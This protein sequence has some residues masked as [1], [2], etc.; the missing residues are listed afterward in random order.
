MVFRLGIV[1]DESQ[2]LAAIHSR[3]IQIQQGKIG[4]R[5]I[6]KNSL[7][8]EK[9]HGLDAVGGHIQMDGNIGRVK[10][11][12]GQPYISGAVFDQEDF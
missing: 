12:L 1:L 10:G 3:H 5:G 9:R 7:M 8:P 2:S 4:A 6:G 11:F